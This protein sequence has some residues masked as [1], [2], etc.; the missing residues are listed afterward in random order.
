[1]GTTLVMTQQIIT[2]SIVLALYFTQTSRIQVCNSVDHVWNLHCVSEQSE[3]VSRFVGKQEVS[4][5]D[6][7]QWTD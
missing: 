1:M 4:L 7:H 2:I 5:V 6:I 3:A